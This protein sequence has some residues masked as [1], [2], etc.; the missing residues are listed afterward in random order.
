MVVNIVNITTILLVIF[1]VIALV[2]IIVFLIRQQNALNEMQDDVGYSNVSYISGT[3]ENPSPRRPGSSSSNTL[4][5]EGDAI[6][7]DYSD[8]SGIKNQ[9]I[10]ARDDFPSEEDEMKDDKVSLQQR[11]RT[12]PTKQNI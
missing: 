5:E 12:A 6:Y 2:F 8:E 10:D 7:H 9:I 1:I 3:Q 4:S 11:P